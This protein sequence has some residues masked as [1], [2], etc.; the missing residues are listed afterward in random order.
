MEVGDEVRVVRDGEVYEG[1]LAPRIEYGGEDFIVVKLRSGYNIGVRVSDG[2]VQ[3]EKLPARREVR[4][5]SPVIPEAKATLPS[6]AILGTGGTIA[7][8]V[9]YRT[10]AVTPIFSADDLYGFT[11]ELA[12]IARIDVETVFNIFSE[13]MTPKHWS[14]IAY[15]IGEYVSKGID[16]IIV[17]HGTD[18]MGYTAAALSFA[19]R[20]LPVPVILVGAQRS[21][22]RPSSDAA[23]NLIGAVTA[24]AYAPFAE[25]VVAMHKGLSDDE[26]A[27]HRGTRVRKCHTSRRDAF[28]SIN[29]DQVAVYRDY[30]IEMLTEDYRRR[31]EDGFRVEAEFEERVALIK[32]Y[33]GF[34]PKIIEWYIDDGYRGL[35]IEGTGLGH[36]S[37]RCIPALKRA[38]DSGVFVGMTSQCL[39][40]RINMSV[41]RT[42]RELQ[43]VGVVPLE[44]MLPETALVKLMW[45]LARVDDVGEARRLM[46][47]NIAGE[48]FRRTS[49]RW[50]A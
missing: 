33:P 46:L 39:W 11:P 35:V 28:K 50:Y 3:V 24:A 44:D 34:D 15:K 23:L 38:V 9:D 27:F 10:G 13:D 18:T 32:F 22:D 14:I 45:V 48:I 26:V 1:V 49:F 6:V 2:K 25:V 31:G 5:K 17:T 36:V 19:L 8:R 37:S 12:G 40:G 43:A 7:S 29:S 42:G 21:P 41:Y 16:G 4:Y 47:T 30:K 20:N